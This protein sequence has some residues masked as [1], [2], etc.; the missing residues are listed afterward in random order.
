MQKP[1]L[2][3]AMTHI[4]VMLRLRSVSLIKCCK[5][6]HM[7]ITSSSPLFRPRFT[8][9][10]PPVVHPTCSL[11]QRSSPDAFLSERKSSLR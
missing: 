3:P 11:P 6:Y 1:S 2:I 10:S 5:G 4:K 7:H 8:G 9:T